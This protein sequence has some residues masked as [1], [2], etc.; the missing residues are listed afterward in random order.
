MFLYNENETMKLIGHQCTYGLIIGDG[1]AK[2]DFENVIEAHKKQPKCTLFDIG[3]DMFMLG[4]IY[5][6]RA[7]RK[8]RK[9]VN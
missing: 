2:N 8:G 7:E 9:N 1:I 5:G 4:Y 3:I 6:K